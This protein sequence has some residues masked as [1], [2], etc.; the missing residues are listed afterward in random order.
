MSQDPQDLIRPVV[1]GVR[2]DLNATAGALLR[3]TKGLARDLEH[4]MYE[5]AAEESARYALAHMINARPIRPRKF[6]DG[7]RLELIEHALTLVTVDG[8]YAEFGVYKGESLGFIADRIDTVV[9][10]FDSFEGLPGDWFLEYGKGYFDLK[11]EPPNFRTAQRNYRLLKGWFHDSLPHFTSQIDGPAAFLHIDCDLYDSTRA[12][13]EGLTGRIVPGTVIVLA[14]YL[15]YPGWER[16]EFKAF[17]EFC[18][19]NA[20]RY[21]Y[22]AFAPNAYGAAVVIEDVGG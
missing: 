5:L 3:A 7:G 22:A 2:A 21:R 10:G 15:N 13:L 11:G 6:Q 17:Q 20:V 18:Q 8:F 4:R 19:A 16:H 12:V 1:E 14:E 9:Y